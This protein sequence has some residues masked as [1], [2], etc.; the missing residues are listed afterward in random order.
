MLL[1]SGRFYP[2]RFKYRECKESSRKLRSTYDHDLIGKVCLAIY[3]YHH[4]QHICYELNDDA[5]NLYEQI[6]DRYNE[7]FNLKYAGNLLFIEIFHR[8]C[9]TLAAFVMFYVCTVTMLH[10]TIISFVV[11]DE[12]DPMSSQPKL[13]FSERCEISVRTKAAELIGRLATVLWIYCNGT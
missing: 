1:I 12:E 10:I 2:Y 3:D 8:I 4:D 9:T 5:E 7:Q 6:F 13:E 11:S